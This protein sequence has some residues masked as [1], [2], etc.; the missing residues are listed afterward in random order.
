MHAPLPSF[1]LFLTLF[2]PH[3][4]HS[5]AIIN[6]QSPCKLFEINLRGIKGNFKW[7]SGD[8]I[9]ILDCVAV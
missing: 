4:L 9:C 1:V 7:W 2:L 8:A 3:T 6:L 5:Q